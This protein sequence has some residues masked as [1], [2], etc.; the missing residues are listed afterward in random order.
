MQEVIK[1]IEALFDDGVVPSDEWCEDLG[2]NIASMLKERL[3]ER[4]DDKNLRMSSLGR[5]NRYLWYTTRDIKKEKLTASTRIKFL[6]G[7]IIELLF[8][9]LIRLSG[10]EVA[11]EQ[12]EVE[13]NGIK[14]HI[15]CT[16]DGELVDIKSASSFSYIKFKDGK[17]SGEGN[18]PFG[19]Y[20]QLSA[21]AEASGFKPAGWL[22]MDK[23]LGKLC[24]SKAQEW[25]MPDMMERSETVKE[26]VAQSQ[27]PSPCAE[28]VAAGKSGNR[29]LPVTCSYCQ[30]KEHC[31]R[32]TNQGHGLRVFAYASS[33]E[34]LTHVERLPKVPEITTKYFEEE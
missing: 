27:E 7:D 22:V 33:I 28:P 29:K 1:D 13:L 23:Q 32:N 26:V 12:M 17:L 10:H 30:F 34:F 16:V 15:D 14:G 31:W 3:A 9:S 18:D 24:F 6:Y 20:A 8:I 21:Y 19:Y 5:G 25:A 11:N 2:H 4:Q